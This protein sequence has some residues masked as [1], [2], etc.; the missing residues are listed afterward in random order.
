MNR[1]III[2]AVCGAL[3]VAGGV[4]YFVN[5]HQHQSHV[6]ASHQTVNPTPSQSSSSKSST[7]APAPVASPAPASSGSSGSVSVSTKSTSTVN[8]QTTVAPTNI[9]FNATDDS[10]SQLSFGVAKGSAVTMTINVSSSGAYH[11]GLMFKSNSPALNS[12]VIAPGASGTLHFTA[13][14]SFTLQPYWADGTPKGYTIAVN[15]S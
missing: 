10:A 14:N 3:V 8:G 15:V 12:G 5:R 4:V 6:A 11:K 1:P 2:S 7:P 9:T 13:A